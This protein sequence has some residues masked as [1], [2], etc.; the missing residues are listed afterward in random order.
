MIT[1]PTWPVFEEDEI[2]A[3]K[4][5]LN[6]GKVNYWTGSECREFEAEFAHY[7]GV[8]HAIAVSNGT[9][10]IELALQALQIGAGDEV[11]VPSATFIATASAVV[12]RGAK[13]ICADIDEYSQNITATTIAPLITK[14][15]KAIICVHLGGVPCEMDDI[16]ALATAHNLTVIEDC[17]QSHGAKYKGKLTGSIG[18]INAFSFCQDK[19]MTTGG[20]GGLVVTNNTELYKKA[21]SF[22]EHG[23][24]YDTVFH[25]QHPPGFRWLHHQFGTNFR[26][27][28]MQAAIGR[29]QLKKL[30]QWVQKRT[31]NALLLT[32]AFKNHPLVTIPEI[33]NYMTPA[34]YKFYLFIHTEKLK[35]GWSRDRIIAEINAQG[36]FCTTGSCHEIYK[37]KAF[38]IFPESRNTPRPIAKSVDQ[39]TIMFQVHPTL[40]NQ[41]ILEVIGVVN[42]VLDSHG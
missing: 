17:A 1:T 23:K 2:N 9:V 24:D 4:N 18:H 34:F 38:D 42:Q 40:R 35:E 11:I 22:K 28:E 6:S 39:K 16:M 8:N 3:V 14:N 31:Q 10:A 41:D 27:T 33:P 29:V 25:T 37:E 5:V 36:V 15:T 13:P 19:I 26:L 30:D 21:W 32:S 12:M 7:L 20:E